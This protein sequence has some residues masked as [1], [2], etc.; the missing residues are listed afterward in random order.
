MNPEDIETINS[1]EVTAGVGGNVTR[2]LVNEYEKTDPRAA[3]SIKFANSPQVQ[4]YLITRYRDASSTAS[5]NGYGG[6]NTPII[7][8]AEVILMLAE[9]K[10][11]LGNDALA[12]Q[13]GNVNVQELLYM[14][15]HA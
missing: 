4:D 14:L 11:Y 12:I 5:V 3:I 1:L 13:Y 10:M 15:W 6:N 7:R 8:Y 2:D 9:V